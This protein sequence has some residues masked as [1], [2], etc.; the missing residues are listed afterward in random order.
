VFTVSIVLLLAAVVLSNPGG[1]AHA[2]GPQSGVVEYVAITLTNSQSAATPTSFQQQLTIDWSTYSAYL[3]SNVQN[4]EFFTAQWSPLYAWCESSCSSSATSSVVWVNLGSNTIAGS[5]GTLTIV[6]GFYST[7]TNEYSSTGYWGAYPG[8]TGTYGQ[9]DNGAKVFDLY[10]NGNTATSS[11]SLGTSATLAQKTGV[12]GPSGSA[13][14]INVL[15]LIGYGSTNRVDL[16]FNKALSNPAA[17]EIAESSFEIS[18]S[19]DTGHNSGAA[20]FCDNAAAGSASNCDSTDVGYGST[21][22]SYTYVSGG[23][24]TA[25]VDKVGTD[26]ASTWYY[27]ATAYPGTSPS[28]YSGYV[29]SSLYSSYN[30]ATSSS[31]IKSASSLY[32]SSV[33][34]SSNSY[35]V[36]LYFNWGRARAYPPS[37]VMPSASFAAASSALAAPVAYSN[38]GCTT[39]STS[40]DMGQYVYGGFTVAGSGGTPWSFNVIDQAGGNVKSVSP[41]SSSPYCDSAGYQIPASSSAGTWTI[42]V[43]DTNG[44]NIGQVTFTVNNV[45]IPDL[46]SG[47]LFLLLPVVALYMLARRRVKVGY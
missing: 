20:G 26:A 28:A 33:G 27:A 15:S 16:V 10:F 43:L 19:G 23:T 8:F 39:S 36:G 2:S 11:F 47:V 14:T 30:T 46:P 4:V 6:M 5:G 22:E 40:F 9:Y 34:A 38:S 29:A 18:N 25:G 45:Q 13:G 42:E 31:P 1:V 44:V 41:I 7:G 35:P 17:G 24:A 3:A 21:L 32:W 12:T 37:G